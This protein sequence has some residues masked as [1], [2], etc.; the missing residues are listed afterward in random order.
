MN[1][2]KRWPGYGRTSGMRCVIARAEPAR[3]GVFCV[4]AKGV[5][6]LKPAQR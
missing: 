1:N 2:A 4:F 5:C 6:S 3:D